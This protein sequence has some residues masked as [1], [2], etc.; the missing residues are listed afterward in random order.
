M[1]VRG[2]VSPRSSVDRESGSSDSAEV[3]VLRER[4]TGNTITT[5][6]W[7]LYRDG[8]MDPLPQL[9]PSASR[10]KGVQELHPEQLDNNNNHVL[11]M[12]PIIECS[13]AGAIPN[14]KT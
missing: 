5:I 11:H 3:L 12:W 8:S 13:W 4:L 7:D 9:P 6:L 1:L 14:N 10:W 2:K